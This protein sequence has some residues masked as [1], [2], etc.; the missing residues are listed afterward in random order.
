MGTKSIKQSCDKIRNLM[1]SIGLKI[2]LSELNINKPD[3]KNI[4]REGF[5]NERA[6]NNPKK[7]LKKDAE[8]LLN[9]IL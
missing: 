2:N 1:K 7:I 3:I 5:Y 9:E 6:D 4:I 8:K